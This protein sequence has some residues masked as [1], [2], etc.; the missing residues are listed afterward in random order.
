MGDG[1]RTTGCAMPALRWGIASPVMATIRGPF[2]ANRKRYP[3]E[4][5]QRRA[6]RYRAAGETPALL[7][8]FREFRLYE[9]H[10]G[11]EGGGGEV[12]F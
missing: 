7:G 3:R 12:E 4:L 10:E 11:G 6:S 5:E 9:F 1:G 8:E 2:G